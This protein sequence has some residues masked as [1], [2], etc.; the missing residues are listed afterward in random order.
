MNV[1][2]HCKES[3]DV[4]SHVADAREITVP[5]RC[6][7]TLNDYLR[8]PRSANQSARLDPTGISA[9]QRSCLKEDLADVYIEG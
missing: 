5:L 9:R 8:Q 6:S 3:S 1:T 2:A 7:V 4:R